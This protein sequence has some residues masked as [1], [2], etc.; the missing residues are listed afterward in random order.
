MNKLFKNFFIK[1]HII[2][3]GAMGSYLEKLGFKD[4]TP[5]I[6]NIKNPEIV[7]KIHYQYC[8]SGA[9]IILTNT[10]GANRII[11][12]K[13]KLKDRFEEIIVNG[14]KIA[15]K[16]KEKFKDV[17]IAGDI[18]PTG[19][20]L[21]P[22]GNLEIKEAESVFKEIGKIFQKTDVDFL[23]LETFQDLEELKIAYNTL[24]ENTHF[25]IVPCLTFA[26]GKEY[27]TLMGQ[28]I[29]EYLKWAEK[30]KISIIGSNCGLSSKEIIGLVEIIRSITDLELWMKPNAG[31]P[32]IKNGKIEY[33]E[34]IEEF[35]ENCVKIAK[36]GVKFIGGCCG[37]TPLYIKNLKYK[38]DE[39][40]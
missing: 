22:Y 31:I 17:L 3:D 19:E 37:T 21:T 5:E 20:L 35:V 1:K 24:K 15:F 32:K 11:L 26:Y 4:I 6:A 29:D 23:V 13:K 30:N 7:E 36:I 18:G 12:D 16:V 27:R 8:E 14:F 38:L 34:S 28:K 39:T 40:C 2:L 33:Q 25:Y 9:E 10:F